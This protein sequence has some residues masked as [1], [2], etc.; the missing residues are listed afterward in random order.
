[1]QATMQYLWKCPVLYFVYEYFVM[2]ILLICCRK[3]IK[4]FAF[5]Y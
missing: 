3:Q 2:L 1:M 4:E 5:E